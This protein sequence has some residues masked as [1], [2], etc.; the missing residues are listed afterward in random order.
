MRFRASGRPRAVLTAL[1][2]VGVLVLAGCGS[3]AAQGSNSD[4]AQVDA[5]EAPVNLD[6]RMLTP[7]DVELPSNA[8]KTVPCSEPHTAQTFEVA[9]VPGDLRDADYGSKALGAYAYRQCSTAFMTFTGGDDSQVMRSVVSWAWF[10][11]S[12]AAW[13][14]GARWYR[15]DL[16]GG[17]PQS[18][19]YVL[20]PDSA[21]GLL[22]GQPEDQWLACAQGDT[23]AGST[24]VP[25][26]TKH[27]WRAVTT[28]KLG[29]PDDDGRLLLDCWQLDD[30]GPRG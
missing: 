10:R 2:A 13:E 29:E 15:C 9:E 8:S 28:I 21:Q 6:C 11:P 3:K 27:Q 30:V 17:G 4:P 1:L 5:T 26:S 20:L 22:H 19:S 7:S 24:K 16:V 14:K 23:F 12:E 18:A 25:C